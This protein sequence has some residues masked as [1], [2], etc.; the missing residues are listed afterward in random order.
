MLKHHVQNYTPS[1]MCVN[2]GSN[3]QH[4]HTH[5]YACRALKIEATHKVNL[6]EE[7]RRTSIQKAQL[8]K[9]KKKTS[10]LE[11]I[12]ACLST[13]LA[14]QKTAAADALVSLRIEQQKS[15]D[16]AITELRNKF[17]NQLVGAAAKLRQVSSTLSMEKS[18]RASTQQKLDRIRATHKQSC[19]TM[20]N[21]RADK[22]FV[23]YH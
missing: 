3:T 17:L 2:H 9:Q 1:G 13:K 10:R 4:T 7:R 23:I 15:H 21:L 18:Q 16:R 12:V 5:I 11:A 6:E 19:V 8:T 14:N 20:T 22:R